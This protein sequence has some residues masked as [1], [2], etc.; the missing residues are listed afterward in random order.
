MR[1]TCCRKRSAQ[2]SSCA[3]T[4]SFLLEFHDLCKM[5]R[6]FVRSM[7]CHFH[8][9]LR[10]SLSICLASFTCQEDCNYPLYGVIKQLVVSRTYF[11]CFRRNG[12]VNYSGQKNRDSYLYF[13][14]PRQS[15]H[16]VICIR[17]VHLSLN[18]FL[19]TV[20]ACTYSVYN[21]RHG[22]KSEARPP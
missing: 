18:C 12:N 8:C 10:T 6:I 16:W 22:L 21:G 5:C 11:L 3:L 20:C 13:L 1:D 15:H 17:Y 4:I 9:A 2:S 19:I 7:L 14:F